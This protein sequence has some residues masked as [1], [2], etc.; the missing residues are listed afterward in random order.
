MTTNI[1][2]LIDAE[3]ITYKELPNIV[4]QVSHHGRI[5][6]TAVY[7]DWEQPT[8]QKWHEVAVDNH[9][10]I[11]HQ[12]NDPNT[13]NSTDMRLILDAMDVL[14]RV[15]PD[16]LC[17]A[18]N[19][20]DY[21]P[22]CDKI[23]EMGKVVIGV[24]YTDHAA[25][26]LIRSCDHFVFL[27]NGKV[28]QRMTRPP[29]PS[30]TTGIENSQAL[31]KLL[32]QAFANE[33]WVTLSALG[34]ALRKVESDFTT[35]KYGHANLSKLLKSMPDFI[36][37]QLDGSVASARLI[38]NKQT[39]LNATQKLLVKAFA[40]QE[41]EPQWMSLSSLGTALRQIKADFNPGSYGYANLTK[42]LESMPDVVELHT[43]DN[44]T[45]TRLKN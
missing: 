24:G 8:L 18:S 35:K 25:E 10:K 22:L 41:I 21:V 36:D 7:G 12:T 39:K 11:R 31:I 42:L 27:R 43:I 6:L 20:A 40:I 14:H 32:T 5:I 2:L 33:Q 13:K 26:A 37:F 44:I 28:P 23:H 16:A 30:Q 29:E 19:D 15:R 38:N 3:N 17:I 4:K 1:A 45:S 34:T 9:L